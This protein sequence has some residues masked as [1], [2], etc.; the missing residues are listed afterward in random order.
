VTTVGVIVRPNPVVLTSGGPRRKPPRPLELRQTD[1]LDRFDDSTLFYDVF[2]VDR[3][4]MAVGPPVDAMTRPFGEARLDIDG[5]AVSAARLVAHGHC[6]RLDFP[7]DRATAISVRYGSHTSDTAVS[8]DM[9]DLFVGR[10]A[11]MTLSLNNDMRWITDWVRWHV[12]THGTDAVVFYDNGSTA[13]DL[14]SLLACLCAIPGLAV[15]VVVDWSFKYG[16]LGSP[17]GIVPWDSDFAQ[18]G[19]LEHARWR[20][21]R[22]ADG[23]LSVDVDELV[24]ADDGSSVYEHALRTASGFVAFPGTWVY[25]GPEIPTDRFPLHEESFWVDPSQ[26]RSP[27]KWCA[28]PR[29]LPYESQLMVHGIARSRFAVPATLGYWHT[30]VV[31][32]NWTGDRRDHI[33]ESATHVLLEGLRD[34]YKTNLS[35]SAAARSVVSVRPSS[36]DRL[37]EL[38]HRTGSHLLRRRLNTNFTFD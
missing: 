27:H 6:A 25:P 12:V 13:Y 11:L 21:L 18:Y 16:P 2:T 31:T 14:E 3:G 17:D 34:A 8:P 36:W 4:T 9:S 22:K 1:Y 24:Y 30:R 19:A 35:D 32:T 7:G 15:A 29:R 5:R 33:V 28:C 38:G 23:F 37:I 26:G 10:R 20:L